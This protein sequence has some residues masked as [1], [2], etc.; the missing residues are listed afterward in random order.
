[1]K[2][3][4]II[5]KIYESPNSLVYR[6]IMK[7]DNQ[8]II[9]KILKENY[10][11]ASEL[12]RY[13]QEY[14][15]TRSLNLDSIIKAY[16]LQ[17][18]DNSLV[19]LLEDFGGQSLNLLLS[20]GQLSLENF[21][22]I[23]IKTTES[24]AAIHQANIIHKDINPSNIVYNPQTEQLKIIDFGLSTRLSQEFLTVIPPNQLEGTLAY[25]APEQTGRMNRGIDYRSDFYSLGVTFYELLTNKLPFETTDP[26]ELVHCHI[27]QQPLPVHE[28]IPDLPLVVSKIISKLLAKT[29]EERY[30]NA[31]GIKADLE[32]CLDKFKTLG[33]ISEFPL[34]NQDIAEKFHIPQKLYG[35]EQK[36]EQLLTAFEQVSLGKTGMILIS[37]YSGIGKSA[38]VNEIHK[39]ITKQ[40]GRFI[41][42][43]F[44][45]LQRDIPYSA[46][47]QAFQD[48][49][50]KL[51]SEPDITLQ[52]WKN[53]ILAVLG[54]NG[55]IIID[56]IPELEKI[57]GQQPPVEQLGG[58][59]SQNRFNLL[60]QIFLSLFCKKEHPLV[61]FIDDLQWADLPSLNLIEQ[62]ILDS[63]NQY[64]L[65]IG[66]YRDN[67]VNPTHPLMHT[68]EKIKQAK[69]P[70]N[71]ITLYP[72]KIH[73]INQLI[74]DT[75]SCST[76][77]TKPLAELVAKK[78]GGNPFFLTQLLYSLYQE[79]LLVFNSRQSKD[80]QQSYWQW[81]IDEIES[82]SITD[83]V[84]NLMVRKIEKLDQ[85]T[86][87]VLKLAACIGNHFNLEI[88]SIVNNKSQEVTAKEIQSALDQGLIIPLDNNYKVPLLWNPEELSNSSDISSQHSTF[89]P[90]KF[91]HDRVQQA[92]Y[93]LIPEAEKKQVHLQ[94]GRLLLKNIKETRNKEEELQNNIF[95]IVNQFNEGLDL[96]TDQLEKDELAKLNL[97]A[98]KKAK[99]STAYETAL[100]YIE[101]GVKLVNSNQ[102]N[103]QKSLIFE[104]HLELLEVLYLTADYAK[105]KNYS[106]VLLNKNYDTLDRVTI[107]KI[108]GLSSFAEFKQQ[109]AIENFCKALALPKIDIDVPQSSDEVTKRTDQEY[110]H[111]QFLLKDKQIQDLIHLPEMTDPYK[112]AAILILQEIIPSVASTNSPLISWIVLT[113][114]NLCIQYGNPPQAAGSYIFYSLLQSFS[115]RDIDLGYQ[116]GQ[117]SL[118]L[119]E[120]FNISSLEPLFI[121][122]YYGLAWHW[123]QSLINIEVQE[124]CINGFQKAIDVGD[125]T[126]AS[127]CFVDYYLISLFGGDNLESLWKKGDQYLQLIN[128]LHIEYCT[129]YTHICHQIVN[130]LI[131][132]Q[133]D[134]IFIGDSSLAEESYLNDWTEKKIEWLLFLTYFARI[135]L[136]Y[137]F[138]QHDKAI[139]Y[140]I[141]AE[142]N[143]DAC[144]KYLLAPQ[145]NFYSS[146]TFLANYHYSEPTKQKQLLE[147]VEKNQ[148]IMKMCTGHCRENFQHKYDLVEAEKARI[149][150]Q[151]LQAQELY[152]RA[153]QGAKKYEFIHEE[154]L[155]YER[156]AEFYLALD[157]QEIGQLYLRNA[158][159]CYIRWGAKAKVKQLEEEYPQYLLGVANKT[160]SKGISTTI[161]TSGNDGE[162]LD[163]T[164]VMKASQAISGEIKLENLLHNLMKI[165]IENAGAQTAFLILNHEGNWVI[166]AQ[167]KIDSDE[168]TILQ[169][170]PIESTDAQ[171]S[172]PILPTTVI[173]Y[174]IRSQENIVLND[175]ANQ[176]Q[177]INDP[178]IIATK[179]KSIL[180]TPLINQGQLSGIVYLENN[181][182]TDTFTSKRVEL[183]NI[184]S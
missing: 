151:T 64:F 5:E 6:A 68:L 126:Y 7:P 21:L 87:Q 79:N 141:K 20:Q 75:L 93:S 74:A 134:F 108:R 14:E 171:T 110:K 50:R 89:I 155:A 71:E 92:A 12:I 179:S 115:S 183:L 97:K 39:P 42:G 161:S 70:V 47:S 125:Y 160:K 81:N 84:V 167:G 118:K 80:N 51:L 136:L 166:E 53:K 133:R 152:D 15:I 123:K 73:H 165:T 43:K 24:L 138:K 32:T 98:G 76:K 132:K 38:L 113:Q 169:S 145:Y 13:K 129:N 26:I 90:Y 62:L 124:K 85:K 60:F 176:G 86:Q 181:L 105:V 131:N 63:D 10:P 100:K 36:V 45:Q 157:R 175:A 142:E 40:R 158:H 94:V 11:T 46:I 67:E 37:G 48:L 54:N 82:V 174:V 22:K 159:H 8:P 164:T 177:F 101:T 23:A 121:H 149:L 58:K 153:I 18:Y 143:I 17:R 25:I 27:A 114:I 156:A 3:Y 109:E 78:T 135:F 106:E 88:I 55:Q 59:E 61:I 146:L 83:N 119:Q 173:N 31:L 111:L 29:P 33:K 2:N 96:I 182:T 140:Q 184:L 69:V 72:L 107:Y 154:A 162:I 122:Q 1:M 49:I 56:V 178:Y 16:D 137:L 9:L 150:G 65:L 103:Y 117:L 147:K 95:D 34:G 57:I 91:L 116:F 30:Q 52:T 127:Y 28:L 168:V 44:D 4:D 19:M 112:I 41:S 77:I 99:A 163:L 170:I 104:I 66:A 130:N 35:R 102:W 120:K 139:D 128:N 172:L 180:C 144:A 148:E